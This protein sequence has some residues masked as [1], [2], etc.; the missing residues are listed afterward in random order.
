MLDGTGHFDS[1]PYAC[2]ITHT[3]TSCRPRGPKNI[4][5][6]TLDS[7]TSTYTT[8][9]DRIYHVVSIAR[10]P[11]AAKHTSRQPLLLCT[12]ADA[13]KRSSCSC[14]AL[15]IMAPN[16]IVE[17]M[18]YNVSTR[19][20]IRDAAS[21][22]AMIRYTRTQLS[23]DL[24]LSFALFCL[25]VSRGKLVVKPHWHQMVGRETQPS[26]TQRPHHRHPRDDY[27]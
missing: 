12:H 25:F 5:C 20:L 13:M 22:R 6:A 15:Y 24:C 18:P 7:S 17:S 9:F 14:R 2:T 23:L 11:H 8:K 4:S 10:I 16:A 21:N 1:T 19:A 26:W 27:G 3:C